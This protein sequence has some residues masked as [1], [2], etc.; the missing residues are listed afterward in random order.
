M[1]ERELVCFK[2]RV[3]RGPLLQYALR[4]I[5]PTEFIRLIIQRAP[6][7][8][9]IKDNCGN[10]P[11]SIAVHFDQVQLLLDA[12]PDAL[13]VPNEDKDLPIHRAARSGYLP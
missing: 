6:E 8:I 12:Y 11:L 7:F 1:G 2:Q 3:R 5:A 10:L 4:W 13:Q 9:K